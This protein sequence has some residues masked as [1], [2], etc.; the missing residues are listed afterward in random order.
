MKLKIGLAAFIVF[1]SLCFVLSFSSAVAGVGSLALIGFGMIFVSIAGGVIALAV[2]PAA[3]GWI[4]RRKPQTK[5]ASAVSM[6][7]IEVKLAQ[8]RDG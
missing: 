4:G 3:G 6:A 2:A 5:R 8:S 1:P 7:T